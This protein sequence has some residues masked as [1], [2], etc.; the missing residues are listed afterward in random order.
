MALRNVRSYWAETVLFAL[1]QHAYIETY[2]IELSGLGG[3]P[4]GPAID[5]LF[6]RWLAF[7]NI[8]WWQHP[9]FTTPVPRRILRRAQS[10]LKTEPLYDDLATGFATY[11]DARRHRA[12][13]AESRALRALQIYGAAFAVVSTFAAVMQVLGED[14]M[15]TAEEQIGYVLML[16]LVGLV[17]ILGV[18][19]WIRRRERRA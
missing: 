1:I 6:E 10:E 19:Y 12:E 11:V 7:R 17:V 15:D 4:L 2:A 13:N 8:L 3:K 16:V 5:D 14:Y 9:S 18:T